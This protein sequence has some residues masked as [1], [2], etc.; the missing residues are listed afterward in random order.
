MVEITA[1]HMVGSGGHDRISE[2]KWRN[3]GTGQTGATSRAGMVAFVRENPS[4]AYVEGPQ[5]AYLRVREASPPFVQ[6]Y[7]DNTWTNNLLS[8]S[9]Y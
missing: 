4:G 1:I 8:L 7:A 5:R 6:T 9:R 3:P 2:L